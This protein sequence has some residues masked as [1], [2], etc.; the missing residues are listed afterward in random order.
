LMRGR[1]RVRTRVRGFDWLGCGVALVR[2]CGVERK[3]GCLTA[4]MTWGFDSHVMYSLGWMPNLSE[5][6]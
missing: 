5:I 6:S 2:V 4:M 1:M 3:W